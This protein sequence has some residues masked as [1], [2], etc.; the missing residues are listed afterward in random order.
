MSLILNVFPNYVCGYFIANTADKVAIVPHLPCPKLLPQIGELTKYFTG[1]DAFHYLNHPCRR[2]SRRY[3]NKYVNMVF[4]NF[5]RIY[6]EIIFLSNLIK[7]GL[8]V[9]RNLFI[10]NILPVLRY[11]YQVILQIIYGMLRPSYPHAA[12][13]LKSDYLMQTPLPRCHR[14]PKR[15]H[16]GAGQNPPLVGNHKIPHL[17]CSVKASSACLLRSSLRLC[18]R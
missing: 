7:Y 18:I 13:I 17:V 4:H 3:F 5:H 11:P 12:V 2:V 16:W 10:Q 1:R 15:G 14:A 9:I 6:P 8:Q